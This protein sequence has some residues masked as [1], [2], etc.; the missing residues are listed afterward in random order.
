MHAKTWCVVVSFSSRRD[1]CG[2]EPMALGFN[3][4]SC[5][6]DV[7]I[8]PS[9][10]VLSVFFCCLSRQS[11]LL[12]D[13]VSL[14]HHPFCLFVVRLFFLTS[15]WPILCPCCCCVTLSTCFSRRC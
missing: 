11:C 8:V 3:V 1:L 5:P 4:T 13:V 14:I 2:T 12:F 10:L 6:A 9:F 15:S 7:R